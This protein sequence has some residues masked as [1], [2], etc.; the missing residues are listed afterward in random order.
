MATS[1]LRLQQGYGIGN[2]LQPL[3]PFSII[4]NRAPTQQDK[5]RIGT[6]WVYT[7][8]NNVYVL[9]SVTG[10]VSNWLTLSNGGAGVF[11]SLT[12]NGP[13]TFAGNITQ[14]AGVTSLLATTTAGLTNNGNFVNNTGAVIINPSATAVTSSL[15][16][17]GQNTATQPSATF[18][19]SVAGNHNAVQF[20]NQNAA[21]TGTCEITVITTN[22]DAGAGRIG[23]AQI[24]LTDTAFGGFT[25]GKDASAGDFVISQGAVLGTNDRLTIDGATG[26]VN[27]PVQP[28]FRAVRTADTGAV[29][30]NNTP[31]DVIF[32]STQYNIGACYTAGTGVFQAPIAGRYLLSAN[33]I[34]DNIAAGMTSASVGFWDGAQFV[35]TLTYMNPV[36]VLIGGGTFF[37]FPINT[38]ISLAALANINVRV[39]LAGGALAATIPA[40]ITC[41][42]AAELLG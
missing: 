28:A 9:S 21:S 3:P 42:F 12:V 24:R 27:L 34:V 17:F 26:A 38:I 25:L 23:D 2:A 13:S 4:A 8:A 6:F 39:N 11:L 33:V 19:A 31:Y 18:A 20:V 32:Q 15:T 22:Q 37:S 16:V 40:N 36:P 41:F 35:G 30:G 14:T 7:A 1:P 5:A 10:G 29:T